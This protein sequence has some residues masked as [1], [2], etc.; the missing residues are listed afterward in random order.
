MSP[1]QAEGRK[2]DPRSDVFSFGSVL[3]EMIVGERAFQ[4][5]TKVET[6]AAIRHEEPRR[7]ANSSEPDCSQSLRAACAR[8][9]Q[10]RFS[11]AGEL[12]LELE[13][14]RA[15][16]PRVRR[17]RKYFGSV[18]LRLPWPWHPGRRF[19]RN[20]AAGFPIP[21]AGWRRLRCSRSRTCR[22]IRRRNTSPMDMTDVL[23][24]DLAQ[25]SSLR[26][27]SRTS[28][29]QLKGTKKTLKEIARQLNVD[30]V[31]RRLRLRSGDQV[32]IT[33][34]LVDV[35]T[36]R[37]LWAR[38]YDRKVGDVLALQSEVARA[39]AGEIQARITPQESGRLVAQP[40][41]KSG[42]IGSLSQG[43]ILLGP[44]Y[45]RIADQ[46]HRI[47]RAGHQNRSG[48]RCCVR[49]SVGVVDRPWVDRSQALG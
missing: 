16:A 12:L 47:L 33:A 39:I 22:R 17:G 34:Q 3:Y 24:A 30:G 40:R 48:I 44:V 35:S 8:I 9:R 29:M 13:R 28:V 14:L 18:R 45:G 6:L 27:I 7:S 15:N 49:R 19:R 37:H 46:E 20:G 38:T 2:V 26:V 11:S 41:S 21:A 10:S 1:E 43:P 5:K 23:I 4:G 32:R 36:D 25:I 42:R 31:D